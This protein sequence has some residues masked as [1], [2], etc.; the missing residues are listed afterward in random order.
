MYVQY[1][2][3]RYRWRFFAGR[4]SC[5]QILQINYPG[6]K[7]DAY[8]KSFKLHPHVVGKKNK[9]EKPPTY[10]KCHTVDL[11]QEAV[12]ACGSIMTNIHQS[13]FSAVYFTRD[14]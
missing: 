1:K 7:N 6:Q 8:Q 13:G 9:L 5:G 11:K 2:Y 10:L 12:T 14:R 3:L 4:N